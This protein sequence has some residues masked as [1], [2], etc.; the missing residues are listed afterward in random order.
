MLRT[1]GDYELLD[2]IARGGMGVVY[3]ARQRGLGRIVAVKLLI[4]GHFAGEPAR[5]R[6]REEATAAAGLQHPNI[7]AIHEIGEHE[8][9]PYFSME[10]VDGSTLAALVREGPLPTRRAAAYVARVARAIDYGHRQGVVHRDL[11]PS[12]VLIDSFDQPRVTDFGLAKRLAGSTPDLTATGQVLGTPGY[13]AP[14]QIRGTI[15]PGPASDIYSLG[16]LLYHLLTGR[17]PFIA[18]TLEAVLQ[19]VSQEEPVP[20]RRLN[21]SIGRDLETLCLKC[22]EKDPARR[23]QDAAALADDLDRH[24]RGEPVLARPVSPLERAWRWS[25]R[26]QTLAGLVGTLAVVLVGVALGA[27]AFAGKLAHAQRTATA[28]L[29]KSLL[30]GAEALRHTGNPLAR[31]E[32]LAH[33]HEAQLLGLEAES[34]ARA[35]SEAAAALAQPAVSYTP[36]WRLP[37]DAALDQVWLDPE[38]GARFEILP[39][40]RVRRK[41]PGR[42]PDFL[43]TGTNQI[44]SL[45]SVSP[46]L[47][48]IALR[49]RHGAGI[50]RFGTAAP[51]FRAP[52]SQG[53]VI[54]SRDGS[55]AV[56]EDV[57]DGL[58]IVDL[59][60][61]N[62][63]ARLRVPDPLQNPDS[64]WAAL[65][66]SP[67]GQWIA[68]ARSRTNVVEIFRIADG[69][70]LARLQIGEPATS[71]AWS[72][73]RPSVATGTR[74]GR[75][76]LWNGTG[77][78]FT[79][80]T[81]N[82]SFF[83]DDGAIDAL[84]FRPTGRF[85]AAGTSGHS[86]LVTD[87]LTR[88]RVFSI[89]G[90]SRGLRY[91]VRDGLIGPVH[92]DDALRMIRFQTSDVASEVQAPSFRSE[93][94]GISHA[95][96]TPFAAVFAYSRG[97]LVHGEQGHE[98]SQLNTAGTRALEFAP[99]G[100]MVFAVDSRGISRWSIS[101]TGMNSFEIGERWLVIPG[102]N[103]TGLAF[104]TTGTRLATVDSASGMTALYDLTTTNRIAS[105]G[106]HTGADQ[107][108]L[109][110]DSAYA[111]SASPLD[112]RVR[113]WEV[114]SGRLVHEHVAG[115]RPRV[116]FS[117]DGRWLLSTGSRSRLFKTLDWNEVALPGRAASSECETGCF[118][119]DGTMLAVVI[120]RHDV[121]LITLPELTEAF[122]LH[123]RFPARITALGMDHDNAT[124]VAGGNEGS[125]RTW[126]LARLAK[127]LVARDLGWPPGPLPPD[128]PQPPAP[129]QVKIVHQPR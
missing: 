18:E 69:R 91:E 70:H 72:H 104:D 46:T 94:L 107:V 6:F 81:M 109:S 1:V 112:R 93:I 105:I 21:P 76:L 7:V 17:P 110:A 74:S 34:T 120:D 52:R 87:L 44:T 5:A 19:Q 13:S 62:I 90:K 9:L 97:S 122:T 64:G 23:Y 78:A 86:I 127:E 28:H 40:N 67:D 31:E 108:A 77:P 43:E 51:V 116:A 101:R 49:H 22:L 10:Y 96:S 8:G 39:P 24:L 89:T 25:R 12:N 111:A 115:N 66:A 57:P 126:R 85:L 125:V 26:H 56:M 37:A 88:R 65:A 42:E 99:D 123:S 124:L 32:I 119:R 61:G 30:D 54:F 60:T 84:A 16:A 2:E 129:L 98:V 71:V 103:W 68:G 83:A 48:H 106:P 102:P 33:I 128:S 38:S 27:S 14:E 117:P 53:T 95:P 63:P 114:R 121:Q 113:V 55:F 36:G 73:I 45:D 118:A 50:W 100:G 41:I 92:H 75:I 47:D 15:Q 3:R 35:R 79:N 4:G 59:P 20:L 82:V 58:L 11:K 29:R 80:W